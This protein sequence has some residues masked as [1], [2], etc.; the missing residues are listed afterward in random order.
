[1][2]LG[3]KIRAAVVSPYLVIYEHTFPDVV[4]I[5]RI[6]HGRR[7]INPALLFS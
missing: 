3:P 5:F 7:R 1:M 4:N 6:L 2:Q